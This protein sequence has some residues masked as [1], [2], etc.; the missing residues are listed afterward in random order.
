MVKEP[1]AEN[2]TEVVIYVAQYKANATKISVNGIQYDITT[3]SNNGEYTAITVDTSVNK[4]VNF[5][6]VTGGV[7]CMINTIVFNG[8]VG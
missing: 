1:V 3:A 5:E 6:T 2:V 8:I 4:T 7:R